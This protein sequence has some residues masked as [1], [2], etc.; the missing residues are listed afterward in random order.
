MFIVAQGPQMEIVIKAKQ[1]NNLERFGFL[2]FDHILNPY[3]KYISK[4]IREKRYTPKPHISRKKKKLKRNVD[5]PAA[6]VVALQ[7]DGLLLLYSCL[8]DLYISLD[9]VS[10][11][12]SDDDG[13][14][15]H[16]LLLGGGQKSQPIA[17]TASN[18]GT[19]SPA[20]PSAESTAT[21]QYRLGHVDDIYSALYKKLSA[22]IPALDVGTT[23]A[24]VE[25]QT[26]TVTA[27][28]L[29]QMYSTVSDI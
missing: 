19:A 8:F 29:S 20:P 6:K 4:L 3:Y 17:V 14:Y 15:L 27:S 23:N 2:D 11:S 28:D 7:S 12:E 22:F 18:S 21:G 13:N 26:E 25:P 16:P 9:P 24:N 5:E 10:D 1:R